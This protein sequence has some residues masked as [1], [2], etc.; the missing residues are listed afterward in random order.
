MLGE[1]GGK[2]LGKVLPHLHS[3]VS[4]ELDETMLGDEGISALS[5]N[6]Q[7][8]CKLEGLYLDK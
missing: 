2:A 8:T 6:L 4:L 5:Q 1:P 3:E 7:D